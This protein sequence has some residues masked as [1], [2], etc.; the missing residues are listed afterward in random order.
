[1]VR[2]PPRPPPAMPLSFQMEQ[3]GTPRW[4]FLVYAATGAAVGVVM[5]ALIRPFCVAV[6]ILSEALQ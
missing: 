1:M 6:V 2:R 4:L 5:L 3:I